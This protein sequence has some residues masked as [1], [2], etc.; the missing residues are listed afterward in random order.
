MEHVYVGLVYHGVVVVVV[1]EEK[2]ISSGIGEV[3]IV[4][5]IC[6]AVQ[7]YVCGSHYGG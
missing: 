5:L 6:E 1:F 7:T 2:V 4:F 3:E